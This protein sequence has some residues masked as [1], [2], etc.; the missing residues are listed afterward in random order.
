M[1][2]G[3]TIIIRWYRN[4]LTTKTLPIA[5]GTLLKENLSI[6]LEAV[7]TEWQEPEVGVRANSIKIDVI[8]HTGSLTPYEVTRR[9]KGKIK[10]IVEHELR[11][12]G[13]QSGFPIELGLLVRLEKETFS[14]SR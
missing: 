6:D 13:L 9:L 2:N 7:N 10:P 12:N 4:S 3:A 8:V 11:E 1:K 14:I 5:L